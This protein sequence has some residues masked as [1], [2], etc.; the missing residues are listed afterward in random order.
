MLFEIVA[1]E[2]QEKAEPAKGEHAREQIIPDRLRRKPQ[3]L[4]ERDLLTIMH[5]GVQPG[6]WLERRLAE[7]DLHKL[8]TCT[9][10]T[11]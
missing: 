10:D 1:Y 11:V 6:L 7:R 4:P 3:T 5:S 2:T 9:P 8:I